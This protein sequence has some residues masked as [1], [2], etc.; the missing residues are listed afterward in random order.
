M[1]YTLKGMGAVFG[2][3]YLLLSDV[4]RKQMQCRWA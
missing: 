3:I 1:L 2:P 4:I